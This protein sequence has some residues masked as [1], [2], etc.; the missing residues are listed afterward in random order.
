MCRLSNYASYRTL[1]LK[2]IVVTI[3]Y[4]LDVIMSYTMHIPFKDNKVEVKVKA[5]VNTI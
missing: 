5:K 3:T 2:I 1:Y 4:I